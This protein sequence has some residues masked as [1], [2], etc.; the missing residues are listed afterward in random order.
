MSGGSIMIPVMK[1]S[2]SQPDILKIKRESLLR[3]ICNINSF[4]SG[5]GTELTFLE[6]TTAQIKRSLGTS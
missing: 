3:S 4:T 1:G 2:E 6:F 5:E